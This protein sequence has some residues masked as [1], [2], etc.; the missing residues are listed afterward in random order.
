MFK[1]G[2]YVVCNNIGVCLVEEITM[3]DMNGEEQEKPYYILKPIDSMDSKIYSAVDNKKMAMRKIIT[4]EQVPELMEELASLSILL[5]ENEKRREEVYKQILH[6]GECIGWAQIIKTVYC[7]KKEKAIQ[8]KKITTTDTK[9]LKMAENY[10][11]NELGI[12]MKVTPKEV[13]AHILNEIGVEA[14]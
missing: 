13:R 2:E 10:L 4:K 9:Y 5:V 3:K 14:I 11:Y 7:R 8:G 1:K 6:K 12:C